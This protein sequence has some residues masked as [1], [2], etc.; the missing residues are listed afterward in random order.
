MANFRTL[1]DAVIALKEY[2]SATDRDELLAEAVATV[3]T[4]SENEKFLYS[5]LMNFVD[6][7]TRVSQIIKSLNDRVS[8]DAGGSDKVSSEEIEKLLAIYY[9]AADPESIGVAGS[10]QSMTQEAPLGTPSLPTKNSSTVAI[11]QVLS[12]NI[13]PAN[14]FTDAAAL[15]LTA[16]PTAE[17]SRSIPVIDLN[18]ILPRPPL[19]T[20]GRPEA[21]SIFKFLVGGTTVSDTT[22]QDIINAGSVVQTTLDENG[23]T[24]TTPPFTS[25]GVELF[26]APQTLV[27][28]DEDFGTVNYR[29]APII[30]KFRPLMTF[31]S[32]DLSVAPTFGM[33][34][35]KSGKLNFVLHDR[36]RLSEV[37]DLVRP[38]LYSAVELLIEYGWSHPDGSS[39]SDNL[40][41]Q[42]INST[43]I[44]EKYGVANS[45]FIFTDSGQIEITLE[46]FMKGVTDFSTTKI[47]QNRDVINQIQGIEKLLDAVS[48]IKSASAQT[49]GTREVRGA[50]L[51]DTPSDI[52]DAMTFDE[53]ALKAITNFITANTKSDDVPGT[54]ELRSALIDLYG[55]DGTDGK[56]NDLK[57]T[58]KT[59]FDDKIKCFETG[60]DFPLLA[61]TE[62]MIEKY[63]N[64]PRQPTVIVPARTP[65][66]SNQQLSDPFAIDYGTIAEANQELAE[67]QAVILAKIKRDVDE[68]KASLL[69]D[70]FFDPGGVTTAH[71]LN[72][73]KEF[74]G[75]EA[76]QRASYED[77]IT[78]LSEQMVQNEISAAET[79]AI[80]N[81]NAEPE[82]FSVEQDREYFKLQVA[83]AYTNASNGGKYMSFAKLLLRFVAEPLASTAKFDEVQLLFYTFNSGAGAVRNSNI[84]SFPIRR[85]TFFNQFQT[86]TT[87]RGTFDITIKEFIEYVSNN[88]ID[89]QSNEAYGMSKLYKSEDKFNESGTLEPPDP[90]DETALNS[91]IEKIM[92]DMDISDGVFRM[93]QVSIYVEAIPLGE[94]DQNATDPNGDSSVSILRIHV[95][96]K[97]ASAHMPLQKLLDAMLDKNLG[98]FGES[99]SE[100]KSGYSDKAAEILAQAAA[101][102]LITPI[103]SNIEG[104]TSYKMTEFA[105]PAQIKDFVSKSAP[106]LR[107]GTMATGIN[108]IK[109]SSLQEPLLNTIHM[110]RAGLGDPSQAPGTDGGIVP[111][112]MLPTEMTMETFGCPLINFGQQFFVDMDTGTTVDNIYGV[113]GLSHHL[114]QGQFKSSFKMINIDAYG[115]YR[116]AINSIK[117]AIDYIDNAIGEEDPEPASNPGATN[118]PTPPTTSS[119]RLRDGPV[120]TLD[121]PF[122][123]FGG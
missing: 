69:R 33:M 88:F 78:Y 100:D 94:G 81:W 47:T 110:Q 114:E 60:D 7:G 4:T 14:R 18:L 53:D 85:K 15:L 37:A 62:S 45:S 109:V 75:T 79:I 23:V 2:H 29:S 91:S 44:K 9:D 102:D 73:F 43:R 26:T 82:P 25:S 32:L 42:L 77:R 1:T 103:E 119:P 105:T 67:K 22:E 113:V 121:Q 40:Y 63:T 74:N 92:A 34:S 57:K 12:A 11:I 59:S 95:F 61:L 86:Y 101:A 10:I 58:A 54:E 98:T 16:V 49:A 31:K 107:Y 108:T 97:A 27:N 17:W 28:A 112:Q 71:H 3:A 89:D 72:D 5:L 70:Q 56:I 76:E 36:S 116:S 106:T 93:P 80:I 50:A 6:G 8:G 64:P 123:P 52:S 68:I 51:L 90:I 55:T 30:D 38:D 99:E 84:G 117:S 104:K 115:S 46:I 20:A 111:L 122:V 87:E 35:Y 41:G 39:D 24:V 96:D 13:T 19:N 66:A 83:A 65:N 120:L 118:E 48:E 21:L